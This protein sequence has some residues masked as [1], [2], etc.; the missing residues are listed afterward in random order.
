[1][2]LFLARLFEILNSLDFE[3]GDEI[4]PK[5]HSLDLPQVLEDELWSL[6]HYLAEASLE[7][8]MMLVSQG[9]KIPLYE[10]GMYFWL[11]L[12]LVIVVPFI[13]IHYIHRFENLGAL[14]FNS[15]H[16]YIQINEKTYLLTQE[17]NNDR[18]YSDSFD[19]T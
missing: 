11:K 2:D 16:L 8:K 3:N 1:M 17:K 6:M 19:H 18:N 12:W 14:C 7:Q 15:D 10:L 9:Y 4:Q 5:L 13:E